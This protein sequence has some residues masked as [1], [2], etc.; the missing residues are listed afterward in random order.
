[1]KHG[2][3][4]NYSNNNNITKSKS[5]FKNLFIS[6]IFI[7]LIIL[8]IITLFY[9]LNRDN[10]T[11]HTSSDINT[12]NIDNSSLD[13]SD[14]NELEQEE[15]ITSKSFT[16]TALGDVMCHN[17][18][19]FDAYQSS[20]N[21]YDFDYVFNDIIKYTQ[22][23]DITI[24]S[25]E[26]T[27]AG[28]DR[29]YSNYPLFNSPS[30]LATSLSNIGID[31]LSTAGNHALD[32]GYSGLE[33]TIEKL[34]EN[35]IENVGTYTSKESRDT[36][37]FK[38]LNGLKVAFLSYTYGTNGIPVPTDKSYSVNLIDK[39]LIL[40][41]INLAKTQE[42]DVIITSMHWGTEYVQK[43]NSNQDELTD[44]LFKNG[45]DIILGN[46]PHVI[47]PMEKRTITLDDGTIKD[48]FVVYALGNFIC[49][50]VYQNTRTSAILNLEI[51]KTS[52]NKL[53][54]DSA[55]YIPIY[56]YKDPNLSIRRMKVLDIE[57]EIYDFENGI[58][59]SIGTSTYNLLV[60]ERDNVY[61]VLGKEI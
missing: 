49:D 53:T 11:S 54:V 50:Q 58:D 4:S 44:F 12:Q 25:L 1:M 55:D 46:H 35:N 30:S 23:A 60:K 9:F 31:I 10:E 56:M 57:Q 59:T 2:K 38:D 5:N 33:R 42:A 21:T 28:K 32:Y 18:Q 6:F 34:E 36:I 16:L 15:I 22:E 8:S 61:N 51:T 29:G 19:Y 13:S 48:C 17:T 7:I 37:L 43:Q 45:V 40:S 39:V 41:D 27:F 14:S 26:T 47:Q 3:H 20:T 52:D 24:A